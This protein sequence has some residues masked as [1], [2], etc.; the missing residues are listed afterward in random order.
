MAVRIKR[1]YE[2][3][4]E[5]D[6][7]RILVDRIW[8]RGVSK[9]ESRLD[10]WLKEI[11][12]SD[13]LR[14]WF[15]H[16]PDK[17][18]EFRRRYASELDSKPDAVKR[19]K[20][21]ATKGKLTLLYAARDERH[22]NA[23]ALKE[24]LEISAG[25]TADPT[26]GV[27]GN[28]D[29]DR[30]LTAM[31]YPMGNAAGQERH[32]W[33]R[34]TV[35]M[36]FLVFSLLIGWQFH[37]FVL[38]LSDPVT[39]PPVRPASVEAW[40]PISSFMSLTFLFRT[41]QA[42]PVRPAGLVIFSLVLGLSFLAGRGFCS[43]VCPIGTLSEWAHRLGRKLLGRNL[44]PPR[45]IDIPLRSLKY[46]LLGFFVYA[47]ARM[48]V[49]A[50]RVFLEGPYNRVADVKMYLFFAEMT[51]TAAIILAILLV[52]SVLIRNFW[53]RYLC[54][55]GALLGLCSWLSPT[56]VRRDATRCNGCRQCERACPNR[57]QTRTRQ[58]VRSPECT[59]CFGCV[60]A[61]PVPGALAVSWPAPRRAVSATAYA[62]ILVG[63]FV[64]VSQAAQSVG[65]WESSTDPRLYG[66]IH[67]MDHPRSPRGL[68]A[69]V[70]QP[71][72]SGFYKDHAARSDSCPARAAT[73]SRGQERPQADRF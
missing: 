42:T 23:V 5:G 62:A 60:Q 30:R 2:K 1:I 17:W 56:V 38:W 21:L 40:L 11:A 50:L 19:L 10:E 46:L 33:V 66:Y 72:L 27:G 51:R 68:A 6:G 9:T 15:A 35:Q 58:Q 7:V 54:P 14:K 67:Q 31:T 16:D 39:P 36:G 26:K 22:N 13:E 29:Q 41:A 44:L 34:A 32:G 65:Y 24:Y 48:P 12:P 52:L 69:G 57:V 43:W 28:A 20:A 70:S 53:C 25:R 47:V 64:L 59:T 37:R 4:A 55:Y 3:A 8:P 63:A 61:C 18:D 45:W 73:A 49:E 71:T